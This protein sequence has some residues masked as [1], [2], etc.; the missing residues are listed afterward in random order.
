MPLSFY[1]TS[2]SSRGVIGTCV[3][4]PPLA[5]Q[6][7][8]VVCSYLKYLYA[9]GVLRDKKEEVSSKGNMK[10]D[11]SPNISSVDEQFT[12][13]LSHQ[14]LQYMDILSANH[15]GLKSLHGH[16]RVV[17]LRRSV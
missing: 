6:V 8:L 17:E 3:G 7:L 11:F 5:H 2:Y 10:G 9:L 12:S 15:V 14:G 16:L 13:G 4:W 1:F